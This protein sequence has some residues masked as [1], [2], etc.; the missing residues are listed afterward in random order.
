MVLSDA[1]YELDVPSSCL[2]EI[3]GTTKRRPRVRVGFTQVQMVAA[4]K[5]LAIE[6]TMRTNARREIGL[7]VRAWIKDRAESNRRVLA[8]KRAIGKTQIAPVKFECRT[9]AAMAGW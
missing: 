5:G 7:A 9:M 3:A 6:V 4:E 1:A 8:M 2:G